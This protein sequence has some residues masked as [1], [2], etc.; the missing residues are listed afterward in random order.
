VK[1]R[2]PESSSAAADAPD[3]GSAA[4]GTEA[5]PAT[6]LPPADPAAVREAELEADLARAVDA[7]LRAEA[8]LVNS[9]RRALR[10]IEDA[11]RRGA[12]RSLA[13]VLSVAD[14]LDRALE[15]A[16][17]AGETE[18]PLVQG[19]SLVRSRLLDT[20]AA[21]GVTPILPEGEPFDP[22]LHEALTHSPHPTIPA[23]HVSQVIARG[24][25]HGER[26][27][28]PARVLVSSGPPDAGGKG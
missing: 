5:S 1:P 2:P 11:E 15:S 4:A 17:Q 20:L 13:P 24:W 27:V 19:V 3:A 28:R 9:R 10:E 22:R 23:G 14:D 18:G 8:E 6:D 26:L 16:A 25:R 7:R 12:E 21:E